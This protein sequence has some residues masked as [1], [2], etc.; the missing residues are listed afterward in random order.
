MDDYILKDLKEVLGSGIKNMDE[1]YVYQVL[2]EVL[3]TAIIVYEN[4]ISEE[5]TDYSIEF[6]E[7]KRVFLMYR[8]EV[9]QEL[10]PSGDGIF[11]SVAEVVFE[12]LNGDFVRDFEE[13]E[14]YVG[15]WENGNLISGTFSTVTSLND[16]NGPLMKTK[17]Y[18]FYINNILGAE[19]N[20]GKKLVST[21]ISYKGGF[22]RGKLF[23]GDDSEL[24]IDYTLDWIR[25]F[26]YEQGK[27]TFKG[28]F[29]DGSI[30][31][32]EYNGPYFGFNLVYDKKVNYKGQF[33]NNVFSGNGILK[34]NLEG[35]YHFHD[36]IT[37][38]Y[39][40]GFKDGTK[41]GENAIETLEDK[42]NGVEI[43]LINC[44][45]EDHLLVDTQSVFFKSKENSLI[46]FDEKE[47]KVKELKFEGELNTYNGNILLPNDLSDM[48]GKGTLTVLNDQ[49]SSKLY[50]NYGED[51]LDGTYRY[52]YG[53]MV[54]D[55]TFYCLDERTNRTSFEKW[56]CGY[57][58]EQ[59]DE[60]G[61]VLNLDFNYFIN[62][63]LDELLNNS[64]DAIKRLLPTVV[65]SKVFE[66][67]LLFLYISVEV[68]GN[69]LKSGKDLILKDISQSKR[70]EIIRAVR[71]SVNSINGEIKELELQANLYKELS[72]FNSQVVQFRGGI[73]WKTYLENQIMDEVEFEVNR[74][75]NLFLKTDRNLKEALEVLQR[76]K[77]IF[78]NNLFISV[79]NLERDYESLEKAYVEIT[80]YETG[81]IKE[82]DIISINNNL[83]IFNESYIRLINILRYALLKVIDWLDKN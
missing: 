22:N 81:E 30:V 2:D 16:I 73:I 9:N 15:R 71:A 56:R 18:E 49:Y 37:C 65:A 36:R 32:G 31:F 25:Q 6:K 70:E 79:D 42:Q 17:L 83:M 63:I 20:P 80:N 46:G 41:H 38:E 10:Q 29:E 5:F 44:K 58:I 53:K 55:G 62:K 21:C 64:K 51:N 78:G 54:L 52:L 59:A 57:L 76:N 13:I 82:E 34:Y 74:S 77:K 27:M 68:F 61:E 33:K 40:G 35:G 67:N 47:L 69:F 60:L 50:K 75:R 43:K 1:N 24:I 19:D 8:G 11:M 48:L 4:D 66:I 3:R 14:V 12:N 45:F 23:K 72:E 39:S 28:S 7:L 26:E